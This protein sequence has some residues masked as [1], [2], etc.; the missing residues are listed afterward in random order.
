[1]VFGSGVGGIPASGLLVYG[2]QYA[3]ALSIFNLVLGS[4]LI[5]IEL[6][7]LTK[8]TSTVNK[9]VKK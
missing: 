5:V 8:F 9:E 4:I 3:L 7:S 6:P 1:M 2:Q